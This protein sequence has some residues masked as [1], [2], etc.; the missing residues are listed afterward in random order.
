VLINKA[1]LVG[2]T[3]IL[4]FPPAFFEMA[5]WIWIPALTF[6]QYSVQNSPFFQY[7]KLAKEFCSEAHNVFADI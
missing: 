1:L 7:G 5:Y 2:R 3:L 4:S 6:G